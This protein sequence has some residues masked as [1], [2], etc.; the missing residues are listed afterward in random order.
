[1]VFKKNNILIK[2]IVL[3]P[4]GRRSREATHWTP[5]SEYH[6]PDHRPQ[7]MADIASTVLI[8]ESLEI[9][10]NISRADTLPHEWEDNVGNPNLA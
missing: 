1:M 4:F 10:R 6:M 9:T 3:F 8:R 2:Y 5:L 7:K